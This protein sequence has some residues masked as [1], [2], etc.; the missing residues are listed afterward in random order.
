MRTTL[1][2][3][4]QHLKLTLEGVRQQSSGTGHI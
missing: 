1:S 2:G 3:T 4:L